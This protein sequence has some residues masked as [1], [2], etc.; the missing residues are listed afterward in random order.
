MSMGIVSQLPSSHLSIHRVLAKLSDGIISHGVNYCQLQFLFLWIITA[1]F[2][3]WR[4]SLSADALPLGAL[5]ALVWMRPHPKPHHNRVSVPRM[6]NCRFCC[7]KQPVP[8]P[9]APPM[10]DLYFSLVLAGATC[11]KPHPAQLLDL[12]CTIKPGY[13]THL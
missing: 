11:H 4:C 7:L 2:P 9:L 13:V 3:V 8:Q 5:L 10:A 6:R 1:P 12:L